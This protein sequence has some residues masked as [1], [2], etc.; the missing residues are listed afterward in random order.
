M[1]R[2]RKLFPTDRGLTLRMVVA[3]V[4][5]PLVVAAAV[6]AVVLLAPL[7]VAIGL[8]IAAVVGIVVAVRERAANVGGVEV[9]PAEEP[10]LHGIVERLCV[11]ADLPKPRIMLESESQPNSW[12]VSLGRDHARLH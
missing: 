10:E 3:A 11:V 9:G 5:T 7:K 2:R 12:V 1:S 8:G 4:A 6:A